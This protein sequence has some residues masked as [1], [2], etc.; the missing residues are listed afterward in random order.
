MYIVKA[1]RTPRKL[2]EIIQGKINKISKSNI[3]NNN[4]IF[5]NWIFNVILALPKDSNPH[6]YNDFFFIV[7]IFF[8]W[9][10][11]NEIKKSRIITK[12]I[13]KK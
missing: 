3:I 12:I 4:A 7:F 1:P 10:A 5:I 6:S 2:A 9:K 13:K 8:F 11:K